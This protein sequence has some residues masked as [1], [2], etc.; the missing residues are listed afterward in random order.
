MGDITLHRANLVSLWIET[1]LYGIFLVFFGASLY[2]LLV[3]K[4]HGQVNRP[5]L[6]AS[7]LLFIFITAVRNL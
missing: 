2:V 7:L 6:V 3:K 1:L 4:L 5:M